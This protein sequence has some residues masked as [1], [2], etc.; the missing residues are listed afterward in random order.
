M[1]PVGAAAADDAGA[2]IAA[3][4]RANAVV[5]A[6][7][8]TRRN[9]SVVICTARMAGSARTVGVVLFPGF[10]VLDVYGPIDCFAKLGTDVVRVVT[11]AEREGPVPSAQLTRS[12]A[13]IAFHDCP[14]LDI[15]V[16]AADAATM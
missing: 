13:D 15:L 12:V 8:V 9:G 4:L 16:G 6:N 14:K 1:L 3:V 7:A 5:R 10:E 2:D 11:V